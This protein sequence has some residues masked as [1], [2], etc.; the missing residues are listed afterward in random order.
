MKIIGA[1]GK[2]SY[3]TEGEALEEMK[4]INDGKTGRH[5]SRAYRKLRRAYL[6]PKC[7]YWHLTSQ[8]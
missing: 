7:K 1:C 8:K 5:K 2:H 6:C 3:F 4:Q